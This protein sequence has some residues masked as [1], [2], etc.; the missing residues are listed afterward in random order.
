MKNARMN[1]S[2]FRFSLKKKDFG[3]IVTPLQ[4]LVHFYSP[5]HRCWNSPR[6]TIQ[7]KNLGWIIVALILF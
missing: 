6:R 7:I 5:I 3:K 1:K 4:N 2:Y